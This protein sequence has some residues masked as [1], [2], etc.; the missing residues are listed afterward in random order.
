MTD[1]ARAKDGRS[2]SAAVQNSNVTP[3]MAALL[4][5]GTRPYRGGTV[6]LATFAL[7]LGSGCV[8]T[9]LARPAYEGTVIDAVTRAPLPEVKVALDTLNLTTDSH[10]KFA[11]SAVTYRERTFPGSEAPALFFTF[12]L[13]KAGYCERQVKHFDARGGGGS[14]AY[15]W[16]EQLPMTPMASTPCETAPDGA[17]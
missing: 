14:P 9:R 1:G 3:N 4:T 2:A 5:G 6:A 12:R 17:R 7:L 11:V 15:V 16:K 10:G 13:Q 8:V